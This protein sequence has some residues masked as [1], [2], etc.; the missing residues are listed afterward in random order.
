MISDVHARV[1]G[2]TGTDQ[3]PSDCPPITGGTNPAKCQAAHM[4]MHITPKASGLFDNMWLWI[5]DHLI[6]FVSFP[7]ASERR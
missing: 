2:A 4:L 1:G 7:P 5:A 3:N 6:E